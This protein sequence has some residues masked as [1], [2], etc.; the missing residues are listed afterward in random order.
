MARI[1]GRL[2]LGGRWRLG[3]AAR[4]HFDRI[5]DREREEGGDQHA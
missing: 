5:L 3:P 1:L 2:G 4:G